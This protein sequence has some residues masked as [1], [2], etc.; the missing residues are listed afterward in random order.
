MGVKE[1]V[2][3]VM[4]RLWQIIL[5]TVMLALGVG[6][7]SLLT[8]YQMKVALDF[9]LAA[10]LMIIFGAIIAFGG[11]IFSVVSRPSG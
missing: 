10:Q 11:I 9:S 5:V 1:G 2:G 8:Q 7:G 3:K 4:S 6:I